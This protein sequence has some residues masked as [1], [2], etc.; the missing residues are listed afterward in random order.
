ML[1]RERQGFA[2]ISTAASIALA[3]A[4]SGAVSGPFLIMI[5]VRLFS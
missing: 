1:I 3:A 4:W 2:D 5:L